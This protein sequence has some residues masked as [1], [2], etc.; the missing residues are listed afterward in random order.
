[1]TTKDYVKKYNLDI[2]DRFNH[3]DFCQDLASEFICLLEANKANDNIKGFDNAVRCIRM[4]FDAISNKT[5]GVLPE[6]LWNYFF[7]TVIAKLREELCPKD[8]ERKRKL[9]EEKKAA[10]EERK[11]FREWENEQFNDFFW[12]QNFYS[13]LFSGLKSNKPVDCFLVLGLSE[14]AT[15]VDVR[16]A[17][18]K[19]SML[20]HPDKG[21]KQDKFVEI[22][23]CKNKCLNWLETQ[24]A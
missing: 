18:K 10:W 5:A 19:L 6:K 8:M 24:T 9:Q 3:T 14:D 12:G 22:T 23:E 13:F 7:A 21:G 16:S 2:S 1:M 17:Y 15:E 4:K 11:K 20:H